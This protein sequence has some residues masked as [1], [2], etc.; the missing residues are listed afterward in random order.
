MQLTNVGLEKMGK[1]QQK[2]LENLEAGAARTELRLSERVQRHVD[3]GKKRTEEIVSLKKKV[4]FQAEWKKR[5]ERKRYNACC[6]IA[7]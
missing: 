4:T 6:Q 2:M 1:K 5:R 7:R 3:S